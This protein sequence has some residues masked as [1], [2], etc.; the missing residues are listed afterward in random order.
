MDGPVLH[1]LD[2]DGFAEVISGYEVFDGR[3]GGRLD[4]GAFLPAST[5]GWQA[6]GDVDAD[7]APEL[8]ATSLRSWV[9]ATGTWQLEPGSTGAV[10]STAFADFGT[11]SGASLDASVR[12]GIAEIVRST[13]SPSAVTLE[14]LD[15][16]VVFSVANAGAGAPAIG[17]FDGDDRAEIAVSSG[18]KLRVLDLDCA[19]PVAGCA[20]PFVR[21]AA[22]IQDFGSARSGTTAVD[23]DL[24]GR[25]EAVFADECWLRVFDGLTGDVLA[26][27]ARRSCTWSDEVAVADSEGDGSGDL[28]VASNASCGVSCPTIDPIQRGMRCAGASNCLSGSCDAGYCRCADDS[29]CPA[30]HSCVAPPPATPGAGNTCRANRGS[31]PTAG[32][33]VI[34]EAAGRWG[35]TSGIWNQH[36]F[37]LTNVTPQGGI[38]ATSEWVPNFLVPW[39]N[40]FRAADSVC[41]P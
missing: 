19:L 14:R 4:D 26:S 27:V 12:D 17:D 11:P 37:S 20:A 5:F 1:D 30:A 18:D 8:V 10:G 2:D 15:G 6:V 28:V 29:E 33:Q 40:D 9:P 21:W 23:F 39:R 16:T 25:L 38:P 36:V 3:T 34:R 31:D 35:A 32:F 7:G 24:D 22:D 41:A 13:S